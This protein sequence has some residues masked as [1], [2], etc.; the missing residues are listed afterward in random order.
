MIKTPSVNRVTHY[1]PAPTH[2]D[3]DWAKVACGKTHVA[4]GRFTCGL[5]GVTCEACLAAVK[6]PHIAAIAAAAYNLTHT[7]FAD[8]SWGWTPDRGLDAL[9]FDQRLWDGNDWF[10]YGPNW[11]D[12]CNAALRRLAKCIEATS[13]GAEWTETS[14]MCPGCG[15]SISYSNCDGDTGVLECGGAG[16]G[17]CCAVAGEVTKSGLCEYCGHRHSEKLAAAIEEAYAEAKVEG[18]AIIAA[19][20]EYLAEHPAKP[21]KRGGKARK[22]GR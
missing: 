15:Q 5:D 4:A 6:P 20:R 11:D 18:G 19:A 1:A 10:D 9:D 12:C 22:G 7:E 17:G 21:A 16:N 13:R 14:V 8:G 3:G 2:L